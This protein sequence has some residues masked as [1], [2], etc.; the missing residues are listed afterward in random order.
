MK[1]LALAT[2]VVAMPLKTTLRP[3]LYP[4]VQTTLMPEFAHP[5]VQTTLMPEFAQPHVQTTL[6]PEF[7]HPHIQ[8]T[9]MSEFAYPHVQTTLM[10]EFAQSHVQTTLIPEFAHPHVQT[11]LMSEFAYPHVQTTLMP[12]FAYPHVQTTLMSEFAV[13][14]DG[15]YFD[16]TID[17]LT[18]ATGSLTF[19]TGC[20]ATDQYGSN[21]CSFNWNQAVSCTF[22]G[23]L[24]EDITSGKLVVDA[25]I[26][27]VIPFSF[28]CP[29]CGANC[30]IEIPI[31]K[32]P[33]TFKMPDC[34]IKATSIPSKI[35]PFTLPDKNPLGIAVTVTGTVQIVDQTGV[36]AKLELN[37]KL[38]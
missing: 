1:S 29:I 33:E 13:P 30:T 17:L 31:I 22:Q 25:K 34:P 27:N 19:N 26:N 9:L 18:H 21:K 23:A 6:M 24:Q 16:R 38:S 36:I 12:E 4:R 10:S 20:T 8:T 37:A 7:A 35:T 14:N 2:V 5:H 28:S 11:T 3:E 15:V 32:K